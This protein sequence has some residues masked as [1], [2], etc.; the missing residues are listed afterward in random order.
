VTRRRGVAGGLI[1][2]LLVGT[3][4]LV[5]GARGQEGLAEA[6]VIVLV[7]PFVM[8]AATVRGALP[9]AGRSA[10]ERRGA[11]SA[12]AA[13][14]E[15]LEGLER[16]LRAKGRGG[17]TAPSVRA[18]LIELADRRLLSRRGIEAGRRPEAARAA[19]GDR[20]WALLREERPGRGL[21]LS[22]VRE[23]VEGID[24]L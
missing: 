3:F 23:V 14:P 5:A 1:T 21:R 10:F 8:L 19:L 4:A 6:A 7:I 22:E 13:R 15:E 24:G 9:P 2:A 17:E 16:A 18:S 11:P 12:P 20:V